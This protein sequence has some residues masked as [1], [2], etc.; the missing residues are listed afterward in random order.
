MCKY[1]TLEEVKK[2]A[3]GNN[4]IALES[5]IRHWQELSKAPPKDLIEA[6]YC[7]PRLSGLYPGW[8]QCAL[9]IRYIEK[10]CHGCPIKEASE[11]CI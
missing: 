8:Q 5:S 1:Q 9:C 3:A 4:I 10:N 6:N 11:N 7:A 2:A